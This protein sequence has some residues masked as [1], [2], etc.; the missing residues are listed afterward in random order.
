MTWIDGNSSN[1]MGRKLIGEFGLDR[2]RTKWARIS[3]NEGATTLDG[4]QFSGGRQKVKSGVEW[5]E[6]KT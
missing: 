2:G 4:V 5:M 3:S 1:D 6:E